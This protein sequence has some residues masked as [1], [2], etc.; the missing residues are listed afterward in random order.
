MERMAKRV[1]AMRCP[2]I[3]FTAAETQREAFLW[4]L[5]AAFQAL[6]DEVRNPCALKGGTALRFQAGLSRPSTDL[7][8]EGDQRINVRKTLVKAV[9]AAAPKGQYRIG[10]DLLWRGTVRMR[11]YDSKSG[12]VRSAV[13]YRKTGS[14]AGM[15]EKVPPEHCERVRG[16]NIYTPSELVRRKLRTIV[17]TQPRELARDIYDAAWIACERPD[18]VQQ[19][20]RTKLR[21]WLEDVTPKRREQLQNRLQRE[22]LTSRVSANE[23][24][25]ALEAGIQELEQRPDD[26]SSGKTRCPGAPPESTLRD[27]ALRA[28]KESQRASK[29]DRTRNH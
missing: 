16:I 24:W 13:D 22:E 1:V 27:S 5:A 2:P 12:V 11:L 10:R 20:D 26:P 6:M 23:V 29:P 18:L 17:G 7:D 9:A 25:Q 19:A 28:F 4:R 3:P 8:F 21:Q 15:P 14:R